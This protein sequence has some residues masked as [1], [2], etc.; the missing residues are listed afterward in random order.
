M[1]SDDLGPHPKSE[2]TYFTAGIKA[3]V[4]AQDWC[5]PTTFLKALSGQHGAVAKSAATT[6]S[7]IVDLV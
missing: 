2:R 6:Q 7:K 3:H 1:R 5:L 4:V